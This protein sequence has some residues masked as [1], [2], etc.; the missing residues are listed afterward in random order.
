MTIE[1][2]LCMEGWLGCLDWIAVGWSILGTAVY[3]ISDL[4][5]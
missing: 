2:S 4:G 5:G 3:W 1:L